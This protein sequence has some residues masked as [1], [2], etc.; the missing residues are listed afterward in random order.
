MSQLAGAHFTHQELWLLTYKTN[1]GET[2]RAYG[3]LWMQ[4]NRTE[5]KIVSESTWAEINSQLIT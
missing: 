2:R 5:T 4:M 3:Y 1:T